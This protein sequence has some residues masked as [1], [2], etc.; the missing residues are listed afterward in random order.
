MLKSLRNW[1][2][3]FRKS[4]F[5]KNVV[6]VA[7]GIAAAQAISLAFMPFLTRLYSP[8]A[9][10]VLAAFTAIIGIITPLATLGYANAIVM[11]KSEKGANAVIRLSLISSSIVS[12]I[13]L[14]IIYAFQTY[15][16]P[17][18]GLEDQPNL[19]YLIPISL[20]LAALLSVANY[21]A[22]REGLFKAKSSSYVASNLIIN[23]GKLGLGYI[24]ATGISLIF[25]L[26]I[27]KVINYSIL[28]MSVS[29][30][31]VFDFRQ[32][33]GTK[34]VKEAALEYKDFTIYR[35]PQSILNAATLSL[36]VLLLSKFFGASEAGQYSVAIA[37]LGAPILL[38]GQAV[39]EVFYPKITRNIESNIK[40]ALKL[41]LKATIS[42]TIV[43][44]L[45]FSPILFFGT[46][47]F[48]I[49]FGLQWEKA[50]AF[51]SWLAIW[52]I[53]TLASRACLASLAAM[54][55]QSYLLYQ[56][57][58]ALI[59]RVLGLYIGFY[60]FKSD[61]VAVAIF[62]I[63]GFLVNILLIVF[64]FGRMLA[65]CRN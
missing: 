16:A 45:V 30:V 25:L 48:K 9:F 15:L 57:I 17:I 50:G 64:V 43:S 36:P 65:R 22:I 55:L 31:G 63:M 23:L 62:S 61:L 42:L 29:K 35:M 53:G 18:L 39:G 14:I 47:L 37:V 2:N 44:L 11:P 13:A 28:M 24:F 60:Y 58:G 34:G 59:L 21:A 6:T 7:T 51:S 27:G 10:G 26:V 8:E 49:L 20:V 41:V 12:S 4:K 56:E 33:F 5:V 40:S 38:I 1:I 3:Y 54:K 19:L 52:M 32:W 46:D